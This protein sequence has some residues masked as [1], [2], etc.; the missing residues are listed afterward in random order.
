MHVS[1][2]R[3][4]GG[5][6]KRVLDDG[7]VTEV[8]GAAE[9]RVR[10]RAELT[11]F[12]WGSV[13]LKRGTDGRDLDTVAAD[14]R[15][16]DG[17]IALGIAPFVLAQTEKEPLTTLQQRVADRKARQPFVKKNEADL[18]VLAP[19]GVPSL[20]E[21]LTRRENELRILSNAP[22]TSDATDITS[23]RT[24]VTECQ[25]HVGFQHGLDGQPCALEHRLAPHDVFAFFDVASRRDGWEDNPT[26]STHGSSPV[27]GRRSAKRYSGGM[28]SHSLIEDPI[29]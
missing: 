2:V 13:T 8:S 3:N 18:K 5:S 4:E 10:H 14:L 29:R 1:I 9:Y 19:D 11:I 7:P 6:G 23:E 27:R 20:R 26:P 12:G 28:S 15:N 22:T 17:K 25:K 24:N 16:L 21:A